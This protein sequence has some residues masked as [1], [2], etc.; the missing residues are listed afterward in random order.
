M[1]GSFVAARDVLA[2]SSVDKVTI[3]ARAASVLVD[4]RHVGGRGAVR[5]GVPVSR[6]DVV[7]ARAGGGAAVVAVE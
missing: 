7:L 3:R 2:P 6:P 5:N 4:E 1:D